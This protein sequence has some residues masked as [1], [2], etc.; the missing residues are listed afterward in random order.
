MT[1]RRFQVI[2]FSGGRSSAYM[3][4]RLLDEGLSDNTEVIFCNTGKE[5]NETLTFVNECSVRWDVPITWLEYRYR[6]DSKG[7]IK[8]PKNHYAIVDYKTAS[9]NGEP[10][11]QMIEK[12]SML[13]NAVARKCT[14]DLKVDTVRRYLLRDKGIGRKEYTNLLGIRSDEPKRIKIALMEQCTTDYPLV[15]MGITREDINS[16]WQQSDFDLGIE[17]VYSNCDLCFLKGEKILTQSIRDNPELAKWWIEQEE[18]ISRRFITETT[19]SKMLKYAQTQ[20]TIDFGDTPQIDCF[21][22]D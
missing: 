6:K 9:R 13:P 12:S 1:K 22:G 14:S 2:N 19:Y 8:D 10:F 4:R 7:G 5:R 21:C 15:S 20:Q 11:A 18:K 17:S 3:L 16:Y